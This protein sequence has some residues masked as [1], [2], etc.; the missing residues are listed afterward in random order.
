MSIQVQTVYDQKA[1]MEFTQFSLKKGKFYYLKRR[2]S[3]WLKLL[4]LVPLFIA[5]VFGI[6]YH[7]MQMIVTPLVCMPPII[8]ILF[9][10]KLLVK[11]NLRHS[12]NIIGSINTYT[13]N[14][15]GIRISSVSKD[16]ESQSNVHYQFLRNVYET[17]EYFYLF[18]HSN[19]A[20]IVNKT[21]MQRDTLEQIR[22]ILS[23]RMPNNRFIIC[24]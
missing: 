19:Q 16:A 6:I 14:E 23:S 24:K 15:D 17:K 11:N 22:T 7:D 5:V 20:Y 13:F 10:P 4:L 2:I 12:Q 8:L 18:I 1:L 21:G 9:V 3:L